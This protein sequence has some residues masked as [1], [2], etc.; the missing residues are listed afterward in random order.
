M[1]TLK[2]S[3]GYDVT[4]DSEKAKNE[5]NDCFV[6]AVANA[7]EIPYDEAHS[8]VKEKFGRQDKK[9][10]MG[11]SLML[12]KMSIDREELGGG[13]KVKYLGC[14][15]TVRT[16]LFYRDDNNRRQFKVGTT[17]SQ[18]K[19]I[20]VNPKYKKHIV[21]L[22]VSTFLK[23]YQKGTYILLVPGHALTIKDGVLLDNPNYSFEGWSR[24]VQ[25][26]Y[27]VM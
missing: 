27:K 14:S 13:K 8:I 10:T 23:K 1:N 2:F 11:T 4:K 26:A 25:Q 6:R 17:K 7:C 5:S 22:T 24:D 9:G 21:G 18:R 16:P 19:E 15:P 12:C 20:L 3:N